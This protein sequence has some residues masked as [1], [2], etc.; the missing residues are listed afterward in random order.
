MSQGNDNKPVAFTNSTST[1]LQPSKNAQQ[2]KSCQLPRAR[3]KSAY[4]ARVL[5]Y[6]DVD[7][8]LKKCTT[9][10]L[11]DTLHQQPSFTP[12]ATG[13]TKSLAAASPASHTSIKP[14]SGGASVIARPC[15]QK[16]YREHNAMYRKSSYQTQHSHSFRSSGS[17]ELSNLVRVR[18]ST[19]GKSAPSLSASVVCFILNDF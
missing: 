3:P 9:P 14:H 19:L 7:T 15:H 18:N 8:D 16:A 6:D 1:K 17:S 11:C 5:V 10:K 12:G 4:S 13:S 2:G